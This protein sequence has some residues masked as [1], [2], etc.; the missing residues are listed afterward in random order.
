MH[1][2]IDA[3]SDG[4]LSH[5][6][7]MDFHKATRK[8]VVARHIHEKIEALDT[9]LE[10]G[11]LLLGFET[12]LSNKVGHGTTLGRPFQGLR[13]PTR[14]LWGSGCRV[15]LWF[16]ELI[17]T[18]HHFDKICFP[19]EKDVPARLHHTESQSVDAPKLQ[20]SS[21]SNAKCRHR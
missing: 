3:N 13:V 17:A 12:T 10:Q 15:Y 11:R 5:A 4:K 19:D 18:H 21:K 16:L 1:G 9:R 6:E 8:E 2:K 7:V 20:L 14:I